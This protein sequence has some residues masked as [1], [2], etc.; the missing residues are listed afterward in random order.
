MNKFIQ[1]KK[2]E[3][4]TLCVKF[5]VRQLEL[6]G[7]AVKGNFDLKSN[8]I[9]FLVEFNDTGI[10]YYADCYFGLLKEL[11]TLFSY[12]IE[13]VVTS[14]IKSPYFHKS[15]EKNRELLYAA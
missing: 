9:D 4:E 5:N 10:E 13:L 14:S 1:D 6:F 11:E 2:P 15:I 8:D 7:S 12:P 3:L